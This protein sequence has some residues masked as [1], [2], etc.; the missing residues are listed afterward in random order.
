M[1]FSHLATARQHH[2]HRY[3]KIT[4]PRYVNFP[5][6]MQFVFVKKD[7]SN[8]CKPHLVKCAT[9]LYKHTNTMKIITRLWE[10]TQKQKFME[11]YLGMNSNLLQWV[12]EEFVIWVYIFQSMSQNQ[13]KIKAK[14]IYKHV[15]QKK[16]LNTMP[17][18]EIIRNGDIII[19]TMCLSAYMYMWVFLGDDSHFPSMFLIL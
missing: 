8:L 17:V 18:A 6:Q 12:K 3:C 7:S 5:Q 13:Y 14:M 19:Y 2:K 11:T 4:S 16:I 9:A 15:M 10:F 1:D